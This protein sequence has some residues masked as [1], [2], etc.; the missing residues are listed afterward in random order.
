MYMIYGS[1]SYII[2]LPPPD[3]TSGSLVFKGV[4]EKAPINM[5]LLSL[6]RTLAILR[7]LNELGMIHVTKRFRM[8]AEELI[9]LCGYVISNIHLYL[10]TLGI[11][12]S[13]YVL[14]VYDLGEDE[15]SEVRPFIEIYVN[16]KSVDGMLDLW[17]STM[18]YLEEMLGD[19]V[20]AQVDIF[21]TRTG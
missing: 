17:E 14:D 4:L 1:S 2:E 15:Y 9:P 19:H 20:L 11:T 13:K 6:F 21:F 18:R 3:A 12:I 10:N 5:G 16:V 8:V 7:E